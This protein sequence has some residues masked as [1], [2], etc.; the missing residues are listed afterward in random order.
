MR[1]SDFDFDLPDDRIAQEPPAERGSSRL[2]RLDRRTGETTTGVMRDLTAWLRPDDVLVVNDTRVFP[3]RLIGRRH[4]GGGRI[5][6]LLTRIIDANEG[7]WEA[8]V[9]PGQ[10]IRRGT[11]FVCVGDA[12]ED[13]TIEGEV[14]G[15]DDW[16]RRTVRLV[17]RGASLDEA[18]ERIG[19]MPLPP[20]IRRADRPSDRERY[21]TVFSRTRGSVAAPTAGLHFTPPLL[22]AIAARGVTR[23]TVTHHVGYGTFKP[24]RVDEVEAHVVDPETYSIDDAAATVLTQA[25]ADGRRIVAVGTTTTRALESAVRMGEGTIPAGRATTDLYLYPGVEFRAVGAL[26]TNFHVPRSSLLILVC[27]FAGRE[28][29]LEAYR[30]AID[31]GFRFYS[32]GDA[33]FIE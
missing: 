24:V 1:V 19:H 9:H 7:V 13:V 14:V 31:L 11:T 8:L 4:P 16:G 3:A 6:C 26:V 5:E 27:A 2:M 15:R 32:Y 17:A 30:R 10:R 20:Y 23:I 22:E 29:V 25:L 12:G 21:Q 18:I 28:R 33:M